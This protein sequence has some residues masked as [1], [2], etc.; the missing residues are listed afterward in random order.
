M[1]TSGIFIPNGHAYY[2][3]SKGID[4]VGSGWLR[5]TE[6]RGDQ[7]GYV[8]AEGSYS[9]KLGLTVE[10]DFVVWTS[11]TTPADGFSV[12]LFDSNISDSKFTPGGKGGALGYLPRDSEPGIQ[13]S[14]IGIGID[15]FGNYT[16]YVDHGFHSNAITVCGPSSENYR[17]LASTFSDFSEAR[18]P[19]LINTGISFPEP[20]Q[21][22]PPENRYFRRVKVE[23]EPD[24]S[25]GM[26]VNVYLKIS[27]TGA[28]L[29]VLGPVNITSP[30][31]EFL[32]AGFA[33]VT[34]GSTA[35]H[36]V[37]NVVIRTSG[38]L[39]AFKSFGGC[40]TSENTPVNIFSNIYNGSESTMNNLETL[41]TLPAN[42]VVTDVNI[43]GG[44][45][46]YSAP[47]LTGTPLPDGRHAYRYFVNIADNTNAKITWTG[48]FSSLT[49]EK[50]L[51]SSVYVLPVPGDFL[52][53]DNYASDTVYFTPLPSIN[54]IEACRFE[55]ISMPPVDILKNHTVKWYDSNMTALAGIPSPNSGAVGKTVYYV[56]YVNDISKCSGDMARLEIN[57]LPVPENDFEII[58]D[59]ICHGD[60]PAIHLQNLTDANIYSIYRDSQMNEKIVSFTGV[61]EYT[62]E[63]EILQSVQ[64]RYIQVI[65]NYSCASK[66]LT[67]ITVN[68]V[69]VSIFTESIPDFK[70]KS[71]YSYQL[72]TDAELPHFSVISGALPAGIVIDGT[73]TVTGETATGS[74][75]H[76]EFTVQVTDKNGCSAIRNYSYNVEIFIPKVFTPNGDGINDVFLKGFKVHIT[77]RLGMTI[78]RGDDGWNGSYNGKPAPKNIYF[79]KAHITEDRIIT[80]YIGL[81][82][83]L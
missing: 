16:N 38:N 12:F 66:D 29:H 79:Y 69:K 81:I 44:T 23:L 78:F 63:T 18:D 45:W 46:T 26:T 73:G 83:D 34:G 75:G 33:G 5:L 64:N 39:L 76:S 54:N 9:S 4:A 68:P 50:P 30:A 47:S 36:E 56:G 58:T 72:D 77:D 60:T 62:H 27:V 57:I 70:E 37:R 49:A 6:D 10:F 67:E 32:R 24:G 3:A 1:N 25:G 7:S 19:A 71:V 55:E 17:F 74:R 2:T 51:A 43:T 35:V 8:L 65:N 13:N 28:F 41:D 42:F 61:S 52:S 40:I 20:A 59:G 15:E 53:D 21:S 11:S 14:Y 80:G 48:Y 22:R 31:P 82:D